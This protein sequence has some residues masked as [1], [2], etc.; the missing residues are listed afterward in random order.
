MV[1][2]ADELKKD[3]TVAKRPFSRMANIL[4]KTYDNKSVLEL[5]DGFGNLTQ[6]AERV[7]EANDDLEARL[8][9]DKESE[10]GA[11][12]AELSDQQKADLVK[13]AGDC[14]ETLK[15]VRRLLQNVLWV[16]NGEHDVLT[17]LQVAEV[18]SRRTGAVDVNS[19]LEA[20]EFMLGHLQDLAKAAK[21]SFERWKR[22]TP[23]KQK[24]DIQGRLKD[25]DQKIPLLVSRKMD[26]ICE[27]MKEDQRQVTPVFQNLSA[28]VIRLKPT[29][30]PKPKREA[31]SDPRHARTRATKSNDVPAG[32]VVCG[33][34]KHRKKLYFCKQFWALTPADK[35]MAVKKLGACERCLELHDGRAYC[36]PTYLCKHPDCKDQRLPE[37]HYYLCSNAAPRGG[38]MPKRSEYQKA[39]R[40][41][42]TANQEDFIRKLPPELA[43]QC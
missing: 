40:N 21:V 18:E 20:Y 30:L 10:V 35:N 28:P 3:R 13:T 7:W 25:L 34:G 32:C 11:E 23:A 42:Y 43:K 26:F 37:H 31:R 36:K 22:W 24:Q 33:D 39:G 19:R 15:E 17:A 41:G 16:Q 38:A 6:A 9:E 5:E 14:E 27:K 2:T 12:E 1:K 29:S 8:L 4:L